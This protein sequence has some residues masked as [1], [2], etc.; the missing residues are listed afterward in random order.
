MGADL[1]RVRIKKKSLLAWFAAKPDVTVTQ[2]GRVIFPAWMLPAVK[3]L[4]AERPRR[5][6]VK[7]V[8]IGLFEEQG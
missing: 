3:S 8:Q 2:D 1:F 7:P 6:P 5:S 4:F